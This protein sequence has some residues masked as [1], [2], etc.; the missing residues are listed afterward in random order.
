MLRRVFKI[1][2]CMIVA[3]NVT[4]APAAVTEP[5]KGSPVVN[6]KYIHDA[7]LAKWNVSV[8]YNSALTNKS[9]AANMKYLLAAVQRG[10]HR[11]IMSQVPQSVLRIIKIWQ[12]SVAAWV[13]YSQ[14]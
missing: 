4:V 12:K 5:T 1:L 11:L 10:T 13:R 3:L 7:I 6:V 8:G 14:R 9:V 2:L